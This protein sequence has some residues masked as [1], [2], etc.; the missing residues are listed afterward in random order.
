MTDAAQYTGTHKERF[1]EGGKGRGAAGR[2]STPKGRASVPGSLI[3]SQPGYVSG[4]KGEGKY[5]IGGGS[6]PSSSPSTKKR[7]SMSSS[8]AECVCMAP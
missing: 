8:V 7:V 1:D 4:Y 5:S 6:S 2:D 3:G